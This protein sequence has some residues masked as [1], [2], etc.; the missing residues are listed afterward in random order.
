MPDKFKL[1]VVQLVYTRISWTG[2]NNDGKESES[3]LRLIEE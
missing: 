2:D 3:C 1:V